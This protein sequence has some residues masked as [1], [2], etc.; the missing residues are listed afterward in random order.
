MPLIPALERQRQVD[1]NV[2]DASLMDKVS[3]RTARTVTQRNSISKKQK[4]K[5]KENH[6]LGL[7]R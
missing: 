5:Q 7:R 2:Y 6:H 3:S 1:L 4:Q